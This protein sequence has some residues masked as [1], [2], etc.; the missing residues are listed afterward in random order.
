MV[1]SQHAGVS[2]ILNRVLR[3]PIAKMGSG[4]LATSQRISNVSKVTA[5]LCI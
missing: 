4:D 1:E 5:R 3:A 2:R